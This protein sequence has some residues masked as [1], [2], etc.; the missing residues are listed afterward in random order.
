MMETNLIDY[1]ST[2]CK[3][4]NIFGVEKHSMQQPLISIIVPCYNQAQYL[5]ECLQSVLNQTYQNWECILVNDGSLDNTDEI[6]QKWLEKES[7]FTYLN[8]KNRGLSSARNAG[9]EI[10]KGEWILPLDADDKIGNR[11]LELAN[12]VFDKGYKIIYCNAQKFGLSNEKWDLPTYS[13]KTLAIKNII[14]CTAFF[15][16]E[17]WIKVNGFD[18]N[19]KYGWEDWEFWIAILKDGGEVYKLNE[20]EFYYRIKEMSM[21][22]EMSDKNSE[23]IKFS[24]H[25]IYKKHLEFFTKELGSF[26]VLAEENQKLNDKIIHLQTILNSK[27]YL[28]INKFFKFFKI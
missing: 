16:K 12:K 13:R 3:I 20:T 26:Q 24:H 6:A 15:K 22:T 10:A 7:R 14:F 21:I 17:D 4:F 8:T 27:R 5:D 1:L 9:I 11:Y 28:L 25:I 23:K 2:Y 18:T 19:L